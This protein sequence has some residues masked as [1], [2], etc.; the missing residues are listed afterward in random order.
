MAHVF[1][2]QMVGDFPRP[3]NRGLLKHYLLKVG[4]NDRIFG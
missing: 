1:Q 2:Q 3:L 4:A